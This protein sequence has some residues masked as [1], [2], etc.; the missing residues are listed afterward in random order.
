MNYFTGFYL[1]DFFTNVIQGL[2]P[3]VCFY[4]ITNVKMSEQ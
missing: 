1:D 3:V 2:G 4:I